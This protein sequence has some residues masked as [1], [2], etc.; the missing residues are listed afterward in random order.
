[1][2]S[3]LIPIDYSNHA[4]AA[5]RTGITLAKKT[6]AELFLLH[7]FFGPP[8]WNR[9]PVEQQ[10]KHPEIEGRMVEA[11]IKM[12]KL[13]ADKM[14]KGTKVTG[15]VRPG[16]ILEEI[17]H[18]A[19]LYKCQLII[20]GAHGKG[21]SNRYFVGSQAQKVVRNAPCPVLSV[22]QDFKPASIKKVV[23]AANFE[24]KVS[25]AFGAIASFVKATGATVDLLYVNTPADFK[26]TLPMEQGMKKLMEEFPG[27]KMRMAIFNARE[28][29]N[30]ILEYTHIHKAQVIAKV[31]HN[32]SHKAGYYFGVTETLVY[33]SE[34][35]VLS[36]VLS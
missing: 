23:F 14:F 36:V 18:F 3:I 22:K 10:Q 12:D 32:R 11:E 26:E 27:V 33:K 13:T 21:E 24:E 8:D 4:N 25:K 30:G 9:I 29:E 17:L 34:V 20:M 16:V 31:T 6:G 2:K 1:M 7:V 15:I 35:P 5:I 28:V 19:S